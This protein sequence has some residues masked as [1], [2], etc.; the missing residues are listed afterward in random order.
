VIVSPARRNDGL[1]CRVT[2]RVRENT[3]SAEVTG[4]PS[5]KR[6]LGLRVKV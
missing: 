1:P 2:L 3:T 6:A 4:V 5:E